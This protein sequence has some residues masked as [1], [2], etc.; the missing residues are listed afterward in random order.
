[1]R[2]NSH[3]VQKDNICNLHNIFGYKSSG[4]F[5]VIL[6]DE[7][8]GYGWFSEQDYSSISLIL[9]QLE[10]IDFAKNAVKKWFSEPTSTYIR[11]S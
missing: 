11:R 10:V 3:I 9:F 2:R 7:H 5:P 8:P 6:S 1:M 4:R